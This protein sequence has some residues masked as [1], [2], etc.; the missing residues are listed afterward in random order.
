[1]VTA[2]LSSEG[3]LSAV[4]VSRNHTYHI[5]PS[6]YYIREPHPFHMVAYDASHVKERLNSTRFDYTVSPVDPSFSHDTWRK[7]HSSATYASKPAGRLRRQTVNRGRIGGDS[8]NMILIADHTVIRLFN[9]VQ[10]VSSQ[11]VCHVTVM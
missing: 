1:M 4:I 3:I 7:Q 10:S 5:E 8:C 9:D 6:R 11:L 2:H